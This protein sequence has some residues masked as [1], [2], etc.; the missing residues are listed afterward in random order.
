MDLPLIKGS[1][2]FTYV[3]L[4]TTGTITLVE[5]LRTKSLFVRHVMNLETAISL[6]AAFFYSLFVEKIK[7]VTQAKQIGFKELTQLRYNDWMITTPF[8]LLVLSTVLANENKKSVG[9]A[10]YALVLLLNFGML[11]FGY[12]GET[13]KMDKRTAAMPSFVFFFLLFGL[14]WM[15]FMNAKPSKVA[16]ISYLLF[17]VIWFIYGVVYFLP[18]DKKNLAY[19][20][21]DLIS[22]CLV[23]L[24]FWAYYGNVIQF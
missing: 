20:T 8:M 19:N 6:V 1:F 16:W 12:L 24:F 15:Q 22:K 17:V 11:Y 9:V 2:Y 23:G 14:V 13:N 3:M 5:A 4:F 18:E 10:Y 7:N 21:L